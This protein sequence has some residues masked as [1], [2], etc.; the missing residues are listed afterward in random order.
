MV[1]KL[2]MS[3]TLMPV[4]LSRRD[5]TCV[6]AS[7]ACARPALDLRQFLKLRSLRCGRNLSPSGLVQSRSQCAS[8]QAGHGEGG[9]SSEFA[10]SATNVDDTND[11]NE[12]CHLTS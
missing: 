1:L 11:D 10:V 3:Q 2:V 12:R 5:A 9:D 7:P 6:F 8:L 4:S